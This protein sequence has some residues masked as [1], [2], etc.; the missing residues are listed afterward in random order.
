MLTE[1]KKK[2]DTVVIWVSTFLHKHSNKDKIKSKKAQPQNALDRGIQPILLNLRHP[3]VGSDPIGDP[4][5]AP[6]KLWER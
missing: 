1:G 6:G 4:E 2:F 5:P 3:G